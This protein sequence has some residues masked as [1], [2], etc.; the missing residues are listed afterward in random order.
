MCSTA[1]EKLFVE[2]E[3]GESSLE[4]VKILS[5]LFKSCKN[6][7]LPI[8]LEPFLSLQLNSKSYGKLRKKPSIFKKDL[9]RKNDQDHVSKRMRKIN[10]YRK[11]VDLDMKEAEA[12]YDK[13][14]K[15]RFVIKFDNYL[16]I[17][18]FKTLVFDIFPYFETIFR[19]SSFT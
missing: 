17:G 11:E 3:S 8:A 9:K 5:D 13:D 10:D 12:T 15:I 1:I 7:F 6:D 2:D 19:L 4:A 18:N 14:E 16:E